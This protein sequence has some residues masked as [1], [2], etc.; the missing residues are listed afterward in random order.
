MTNALGEMRRWVYDSCLM[1]AE[2]DPLGF[3]STCQYD[4][5]AQRVTAENALGFVT[6]VV[7][8]SMSRLTG[9]I[10]ALGNRSTQ[11]YN[12]AGQKIADEDADGQRTTYAFDIS[13]TRKRRY[14]PN[15]RLRE[16]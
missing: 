3:R 13:V 15:R 10:D 2:V 8:D 5:F 6:T 9:V 16:P 14:E 4:R 7:Y 11:I 1:V 12:V